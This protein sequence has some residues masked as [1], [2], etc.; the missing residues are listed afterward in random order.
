MEDD[1]K[2]KWHEIVIPIIVV[3]LSSVITTILLKKCS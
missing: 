2:I 1:D 3:I